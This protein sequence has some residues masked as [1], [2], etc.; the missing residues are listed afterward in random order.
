VAVSK[1][2]SDKKSIIEKVIDKDEQWIV[3]KK[4]II[5]KVIDK[6]EQW[7]VDKGGQIDRNKQDQKG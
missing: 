1:N 4:S 5:E 6:D 7:I 2:N 3:D